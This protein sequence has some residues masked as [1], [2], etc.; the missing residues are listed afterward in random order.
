LQAS[1]VAP[2]TTLLEMAQ[3]HE[4]QMAQPNT[5]DLLMHRRQVNKDLKFIPALWA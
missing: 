1:S 2:Q 4:T 5:P 3:T